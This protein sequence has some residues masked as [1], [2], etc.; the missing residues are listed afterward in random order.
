MQLARV[1]VGEILGVKIQDEGPTIRVQP[2][3]D[4]DRSILLSSHEEIAA[5]HA[6]ANYQIR[7]VPPLNFARAGC[8][9]KQF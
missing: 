9:W 5:V 3:N 4:N 7:E 1:M 6:R 2:K 8:A